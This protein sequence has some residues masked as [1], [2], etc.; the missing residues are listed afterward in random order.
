VQEDEESHFSE[1]YRNHDCSLESSILKLHSH[2]IFILV[3]KWMDFMEKTQLQK[4]PN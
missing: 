4:L 2:Q 3:L 1:C